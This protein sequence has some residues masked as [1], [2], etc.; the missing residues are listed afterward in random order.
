MLTPFS[1]NTDNCWVA[2][3]TSSG[4]TLGRATLEVEERPLVGLQQSDTRFHLKL[5]LKRASGDFKLPN[6]SLVPT[7][8]TVRLHHAEP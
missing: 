4:L 6:G 1:S 7:R 8:L 2:S 3:S 5:P